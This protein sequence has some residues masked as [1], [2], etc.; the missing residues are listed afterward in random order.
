MNERLVSW[1]A[2][3][4]AQPLPGPMVGSRFEPHPRPWRHYDVAPPDARSAAVLV[5]FY[6]HEEEWHLPLTLRPAHMID[7]ASQVSL[8][9]GAV[10]PG[11]T[12]P[13]AA[14]REFH[15]ELGDDGQPLRLLGILSP[16]YVQAS[17][18][19]VAPCVAAAPA[20]PRFVPNPAEVAEVLEVPLSHLLD[21]AHFGSHVRQHEGH[22]YSAPH[23]LFQSYRIWG[24]TCMILG[25]L[26]TVLEEMR[27]LNP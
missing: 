16:H 13:Q 8:P 2:A 11:E 12:A 22:T 10:E 14:I 18:Y 27:N 25:E 17:N 1:L 15:E 4:L 6:P 20:R 24:A 19:L 21:P 9:G 5:L 7:H 3:R 26:V 23:F